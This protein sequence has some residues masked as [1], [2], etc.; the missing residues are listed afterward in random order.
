MKIDKSSIPNQEGFKLKVFYKN[1]LSAETYITKD[2]TDRDWETHK[3]CLI[4]L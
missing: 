3:T 4:S 2:I 1:G